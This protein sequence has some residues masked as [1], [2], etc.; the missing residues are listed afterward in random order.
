[1]TLKRRKIGVL[2]TNRKSRFR[3]VQPSVTLNGLEQRNGRYYA[4]LHW[5]RHIW[6]QTTSSW[7]QLDWYSASKLSKESSFHQYMIYGDITEN[8]FINQRHICQRR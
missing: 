8:E 5:M 7:L 6:K 1:M 4:L 3:L 2:F